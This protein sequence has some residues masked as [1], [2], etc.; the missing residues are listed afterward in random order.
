MDNK[1][2]TFRAEIQKIE[3]RNTWSR[4]VV[5]LQ[6]LSPEE[7]AVVFSLR[8]KDVNV[9]IQELPFTEVKFK[10]IEEPETDAKKTPSQ[11][12]RSV[13]YV[14]WEQ[15]GSKESFEIY[16][17]NRMDQIIEHLKSKLT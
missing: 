13:L 3:T 6:E 8:N 12:L 16:Y 11:R 9:A 17:M 1:I 5:D 2:V 10:D 15:K 7:M 4:I 14:E